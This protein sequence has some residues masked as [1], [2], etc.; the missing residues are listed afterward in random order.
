MTVVIIHAERRIEAVGVQVGAANLSVGGGQPR[1]YTI[2]DHG[3]EGVLQR[4]AV[5]DE[6]AGHRSAAISRSTRAAN[7]ARSSSVDPSTP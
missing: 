1:Q 5:D 7:A 3:D 2:A 6:R 4:M